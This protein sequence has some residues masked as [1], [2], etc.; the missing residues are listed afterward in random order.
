M[1]TSGIAL[2][3][4]VA[5]EVDQFV[6]DLVFRAVLPAH[7]PSQVAAE[8]DVILCNQEMKFIMCCEDS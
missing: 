7:S 4:V 3:S 6:V 8:A 5:R 2:D 1:Y